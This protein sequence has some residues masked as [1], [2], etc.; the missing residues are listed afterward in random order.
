MPILDFISDAELVSA[1]EKLVSAAKRSEKK[2]SENPYINVI[3]PFSALVDSARQNIT[4]ETWLEQEKSRQV[5]KSLQNALG[6]FHQSI[7]GSMSGWEN[8]GI[9]GSYDVINRNLGVIAEI[10]NKY[11][12]M[13]ARSA[14]SVYDNLSRHIDY[15]QE[16]INRAYLVEII[17]KSPK[18]Y[19]TQFAPS[20]RGTSRPARSDIIRI[21]GKSFYDMASGTEDSLKK[22]Y[23]AMPQVLG[24][25][26]EVA[27]AELSGSKVF[28]E[29][30]AKVYIK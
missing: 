11:N 29:L 2:V 30:F 25:I 19:Q 18:E 26:L 9:A 24:D 12:T 8:A 13:N 1:V 5:Q 7:L 16:K 21:D 6:D 14:I 28:E 3:D 20:E 22:L 15:S 23:E 17:P 27:Y 4:I 10:K